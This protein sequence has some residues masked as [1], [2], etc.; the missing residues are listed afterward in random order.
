[1]IEL[2]LPVRGFVEFLCAGG[3]IDSRFSGFDR[4]REGARIHRRLQKEAGEGY[5]A[6]VYLKQAWP[7]ED[8]LITLE[9][10]ADG[11]FTDEDG[12][13]TVDEIK[14]VTIP[15][16]KIT[17]NMKPEHWAQGMLYAAIYSLQQGLDRMAVRLTYFQVDTGMILRFTRRYTA[18]E[19]AGETERLLR[20]YLPWA[21][22]R[23]EWG[24]IR[25]ATLQQLTF[26]FAEYRRG[27]TPWR[28]PSTA[29]A[30]TGSGCSAAPPQAS[31]KRSA[32]CSPP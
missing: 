27:S 3:S 8:F 16:D 22:R 25:N 30:G 4:A 5:E 6:E 10:R 7:V 12:T 15:E 20:E 29:P 31:A 14:T 21:K 1:M 26:P 9:G 11:I 28:E 24:G 32:A 2:T 17:E 23:Q 13:A 19:L 18:E